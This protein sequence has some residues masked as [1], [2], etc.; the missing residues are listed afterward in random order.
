[1][2][3]VQG[4]SAPTYQNGQISQQGQYGGFGEQSAYHRRQGSSE[5]Q[6]SQGERERRHYRHSGWGGGGGRNGP[7]PTGGGPMGVGAG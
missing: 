1:V 5:S 2:R 4:P 7:P 3:P 6:V